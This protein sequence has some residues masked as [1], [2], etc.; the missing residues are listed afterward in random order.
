[1]SPE[2][3]ELSKLIDKILKE[4]K[5]LMRSLDVLH[6]K[7]NKLYDEI[8]EANMMYWKILTPIAGVVMLLT[9]VVGYIFF[10]VL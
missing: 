10:K 4:N 1:M 8:D 5:E 6:I 3:E 9:G 2:Q 7:I